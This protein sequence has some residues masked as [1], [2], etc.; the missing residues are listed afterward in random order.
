MKLNRLGKLLVLAACTCLATQLVAQS[1]PVPPIQGSLAP[2]F[3]TDSTETPVTPDDHSLSGAQVLGIGTWGPRHS[4]L[5]PSLRLSEM[6]DS[7]PLLL[8]SNNGSYRG[9]TSAGADLQWIQYLGRDAAIR[10]SGAFRYDARARLQGYSQFTNAHSFAAEKSIRFRNWNL[11]FEDQAQY[12]QGS[13]FGAAGMEGMGLMTDQI[14]LSNLQS[15]SISIRP[16]LLPNQSILTGRIARITNTVLA[17]L[18]A[19]LDARDTA[20]LAASYGLLH[21][22][23]SL[24]GNTDQVS[25]IGGFNRK[26]TAR[27][28]IALEAAYTRFSF[29]GASATV[30]TES[31]SALYALRIS[32]RTSIEV[33]GGPQITQTSISAVNQQYLGWQ[34]RGTVQYRTRHVNL[35][36]QGMRTIASGSGVLNGALTTSGQ[37]AADFSLSRNWS[38]SLSSGVSRNQEVGSGQN[39]DL[40]FVGVVLNRN[41]GRYMNLFLTYDF[42]HQTTGAVCTGPACGYAGL[43]NVF[44]IGFAW[45]YRPISTE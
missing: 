16:D 38:T 7:N 36:A 2:V 15:T 17:E 4:F 28:S 29:P 22:N 45:K 39:Y 12:S 24:L 5:V 14:G 19:H 20:T 32:G 21:F 44:G 23:S 40:Q 25:A 6:L 13:D 27:D 10:Y 3:V 1:A 42:Q 30:S 35:S 8:S 26:M 41:A 33:G 31:V 34:A 18:D 37:G 9:F 43:R 11:L